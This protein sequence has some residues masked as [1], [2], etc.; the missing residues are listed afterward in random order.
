MG[1]LG[2]RMSS[3]EY[4]EGRIENLDKIAFDVYHG[5]HNHFNHFLRTFAGAWLQADQLNKA[6]LRPVW[7]VFI[8]KYKLGQVLD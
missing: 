7:D 6:I 2:S 4:H 5:D 3:G 1:G 8:G